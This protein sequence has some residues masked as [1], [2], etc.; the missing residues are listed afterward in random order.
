[1]PTLESAKVDA[2]LRS[3]MAAKRIASGDWL[4]EIRDDT[5]EVVSSTSISKG[6]KHTLSDQRVRQMAG[7]LCLNKA[8]LLFDLVSCTLGRDDALAIMHA[9]CP[10]GAL[11]QRR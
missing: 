4:Y 6:S 1:M 11:R 8:Q 3:K 9:N 7:Q 2:A 5:G 10:P